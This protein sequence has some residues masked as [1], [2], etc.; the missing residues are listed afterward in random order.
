MSKNIRLEVLVAVS[1][2]ADK[3]SDVNVSTLMPEIKVPSNAVS[4]T[5]LTR[6]CGQVAP[7]SKLPT[8]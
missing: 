4:D 7:I 3:S 1:L 2:V 5:A 6:P 8:S